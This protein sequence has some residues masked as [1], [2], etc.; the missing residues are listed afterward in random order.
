MPVQNIQPSFG[1]KLTISQM[2]VAN[3]MVVVNHHILYFVFTCFINEILYQCHQ[4][5]Y[6]RNAHNAPVTKG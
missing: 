6:I 2:M 1:I 3:N 5:K 4:W